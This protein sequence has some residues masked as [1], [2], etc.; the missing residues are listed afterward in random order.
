VATST[1]T[2]GRGE[3][4]TA[5]E[6]RAA[7]IRAAIVEFAKRGY[8][9]TSTEDIAARARISQPYLFRLFGSKRD[10]FVATMAAVYSRIEVAFRT[11]ARDLSG[12]DA[13]AAMALAYTELLGERDELLVQ[14]HAF[15]ASDDDVIRRAARDG[16][17][18]LWSVVG[19]LTGL[20]DDDVRAFFAQGMLLNVLA[21]IDAVALDESWA[22]ACQVGPS[23]STDPSPTPASPTR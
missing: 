10:L 16:F 20:P 1:A 22:K 13:V 15:A 12:Q 21:A 23:V 7:V 18:H 8:A 17:R 4:L 2:T 11:A 3:R 19:E 9:G 14:L 5:E 6:R